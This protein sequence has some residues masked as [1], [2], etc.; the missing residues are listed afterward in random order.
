[1]L[2]FKLTEMSGS[3]GAH[4]RDDQV[5]LR[6][7]HQ[8]VQQPCPDGTLGSASWICTPDGWLTSDPDLSDCVSTWLTRLGAELGQGGEAS[9]NNVASDLS[10]LTESQPL[11]GGDVGEIL[12]LVET[13]IRMLETELKSSEMNKLLRETFYM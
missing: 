12:Q 3:G 1:M 7:H 13:M 2:H 5:H 9:L 10:V 4:Y 6:S 8:P 11:Y